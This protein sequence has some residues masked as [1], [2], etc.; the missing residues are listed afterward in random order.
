MVQ[1]SPSAEPVRVAISARSIYDELKRQIGTGIF[2]EDGSL[3]SSRGLAEELGVSR[4]TVTTAYEQLHAE[5]YIEVSQ[6]KRPRVVRTNRIAQPFAEGRVQSR[7]P[8]YSSFG[9]RVAMSPDASAAAPTEMIADFRHGDLSG[10]DFPVL[11]WKRA[12]T[13]AL[14]EQR[15][16][17]TY[18]DPRGSKR[19]RTALQGYLWRARTIRCDVDQIVV[20]NGS[21]QGLDLCARLLLDPGDR[22]VIE[23]PCYD[24]AR[25]VFSATGAIAMPVQVDS[26]GM[27]T[28]SLSGVDAKLA[29]VTPSHQFPLG[30]VMPMAR[31][32]ELVEWAERSGAYI[33]EDDYDSEFRYDISPVPPLQAIGSFGAVLYLGT[34]SKTLSPSLRLGYL[35]VPKEL[36]QGFARAKMLAD[37]HTPAPQQEALA[38]LIEKGIYE[39]HVRRLRRLNH[40]R[41]ET[42]LN[43]IRLKFGDSAVVEGAAAGLH[44]VLWLTG[45]PKH[46]EP[47]LVD[48]ARKAGVGVH[49]ISPLYNGTEEGRRDCA[50]LVMGYSGLDGRSI[51]RGI[52]ILADVVRNLE[53]GT[54]PPG[55]VGPGFRGAA[56]C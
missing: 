6:G 5:G 16:R 20:V 44:L 37:R 8:R 32:L 12:V 45:L 39:A 47:L 46:D 1:L 22:F 24:M 38:T 21:Q 36:S 4:T 29:Y 40:E 25:E 53:S 19:L 9:K 2:G 13:D 18:L 50:G 7:E 14:R 51:E 52:Q 48:E 31:R 27:K 33:L 42:L 54:P 49:S 23:D 15:A 56:L 26:D 30:G 41:R 3:P 17:L 35:V 55:A 43:V 11:A 10:E 28:T 34:V